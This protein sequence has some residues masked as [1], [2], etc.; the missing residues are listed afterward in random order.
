MT[1]RFAPNA[2][3]AQQAQVICNYVL[4]ELDDLYRSSLNIAEELPV[5]VII[6]QLMTEHNRVVIDTAIAMIRVEGF[7]S[8]YE[9]SAQMGG[10]RKI[11]VEDG[12]F[13][14][15]TREAVEH[16]YPMEADDEDDDFEMLIR[17]H[18]EEGEIQ[19][20]D[21]EADADE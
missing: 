7:V 6:G 14:T 21:W 8:H 10:T 11:V 3:E 17:L 18:P 15:H 9:G 4:K 13:V 12:P 5:N 16:V 1:H 2:A 20:S 19:A